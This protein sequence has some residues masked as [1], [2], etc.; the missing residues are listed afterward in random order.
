MKLLLNTLISLAA[1]SIYASSCS[2][3]PESIPNS[4]KHS[5]RI[6]KIDIAPRDSDIYQMGRRHASYLVNHIT[7]PD[8]IGLKLLEVRAR[9]TEI[10]RRVDDQAADA[11]IYGFTTYIFDNS[12][13][14]ADSIL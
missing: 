14:L 3:S 11:Y 7:A 2:S 8:S 9:E 4:N 13:A 1:V 12:P 5:N 10:R 6:E